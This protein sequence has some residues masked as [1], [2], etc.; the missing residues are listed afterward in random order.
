MIIS[1]SRK[2]HQALRRIVVATVVGVLGAWWVA[3][4]VSL[5]GGGD[6][7]PTSSSTPSASPDRGSGT[8]P[9]VAPRGPG[10]PTDM[11]A[12]S[13]AQTPAWMSIGSDA[14]VT[15][16]AQPFRVDKQGQLIVDAGTLR[17]L[18]QVMAFSAAD[19][20]QRAALETAAATRLPEAAR[21]QA[22]EL[23]ERFDGYD[24]AL[25]QAVS[26]QHA[27]ASVD[28]MAA[29][30]KAM[31]ALR[32]ERFGEG[33]AQQLFGDDEAVTARLI[34]LMQQDPEPQDTLEAKALRAQA[35]LSAERAQQGS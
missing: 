21:R 6:T 30:F 17:T 5:G 29:Q 19:G 15:W 34:E 28:E 3:G 12:S 32:R 9:V 18:E 31:Q 23:A 14:S 10:S 20:V 13:T 2:P 7:S 4:M 11:A 26:P 25:K 22:V 35:R 24:A 16:S 33:T 8:G 27:P 1:T